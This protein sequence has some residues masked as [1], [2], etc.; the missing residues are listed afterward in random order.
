MIDD[1]KSRGMEA[2]VMDAIA[3]EGFWSRSS[4][5]LFLVS[6][7]EKKSLYLQ[8]TSKPQISCLF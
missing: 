8:Q 7:W 5:F 6:I 2:A 3:T 1:E 4:Y